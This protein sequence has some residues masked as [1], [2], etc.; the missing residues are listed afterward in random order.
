MLGNAI[1]RASQEEKKAKEKRLDSFKIQINDLENKI[2][3]LKESRDATQVAAQTKELAKL[4]KQQGKELSQIRTKYSA[5]EFKH[6]ILI[7]GGL[8]VLSALLSEISKSFVSNF[9]VYVVI[10]GLSVTTIILGILKLSRSLILAQEISRTSDE[11]QMKRMTESFKAAMVAV[12]QE[13]EVALSITF[14]NISG[15]QTYKPSAELSINFSVKVTNGKIAHNV[16]IWFFIPDEFGL[17]S[18]PEK[19]AWRQDTGF[20]PPN[21]RTIRK[22]LDTVRFGVN[23]PSYITVRTPA[24]SGKYLILYRIYSDEYASNREQIELTV[25]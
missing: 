23:S 6:S 14:K 24:L 3:V 8:F 10:W 21:I 4:Q 12:N 22:K 19:D 18:P 11:L 15:A 20:V 25:K 13:S 9:W 2:K 17:V 1:E 5:L 16:E 7:P